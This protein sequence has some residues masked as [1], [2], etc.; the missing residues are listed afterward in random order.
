MDFAEFA[1]NRCGG[2][3]QPLRSWLS[4]QDVG[5]PLSAFQGKRDEISLIVEH[6]DGKL[7][8]S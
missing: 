1:R 5:S 3:E 4:K 6:I 2:G 7:L 8:G